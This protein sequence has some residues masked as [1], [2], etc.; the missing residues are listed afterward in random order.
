VER[1]SAALVGGDGKRLGGGA[2]VG[3]RNDYEG[4]CAGSFRKMEDVESGVN[5]F[6]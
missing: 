2:Q 6:D 5:L 4:N 1:G 3:R